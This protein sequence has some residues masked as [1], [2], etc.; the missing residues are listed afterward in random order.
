MTDYLI[1]SA[2]GIE[3]S[4]EPSTCAVVLEQHIIG[5][6][7]AVYIH[8]KV[9]CGVIEIYRLAIAVVFLAVCVIA[10]IQ[11]VFNNNA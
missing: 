1:Y 5:H 3:L 4:D 11:S 6:L 8:G 9:Q 10:V 7:T 2:I